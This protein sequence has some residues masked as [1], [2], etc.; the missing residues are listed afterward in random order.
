MKLPIYLVIGFVWSLLIG[1]K[2][3][4]NEADGINKTARTHT[5]AQNTEVATSN[6]DDNNAPQILFLTYSIRKDPAQGGYAIELINE[7]T[8][9]GK[10]KTDGDESAIPKA[11]DLRCVALDA[12]QQPTSSLL[13]P[14]PLNQTVEYATENGNLAKKDIALDSAEF[15]VRMQRTAATKF[16]AI[17]RIDT[18]E[19][20]VTQLILTQLTQP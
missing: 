11:G 15:S 10:I 6:T 5:N 1:C 3:I 12:N 4:G 13:I 17:E 14:D 8:T 20:Q 9:K 19:S 16:I 18:P 2:V 7:I